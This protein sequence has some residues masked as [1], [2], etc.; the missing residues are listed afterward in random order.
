MKNGRLRFEGMAREGRRSRRTPEETMQ[1]ID[2]C[3]QIGLGSGAS[4]KGK[5]QVK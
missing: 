4:E 1:M 2:D 5:C 3:Q